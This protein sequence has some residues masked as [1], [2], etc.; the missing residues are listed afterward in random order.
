[1][2][3]GA[4][5]FGGWGLLLPV[6][7]LAVSEAG[8]S[9]AVAAASTAV[10]MASTVIT[11]LFV[12][13]MLMRVGHRAVL[14]A[15]CLLLGLPAL[16]FIVSVEATPALAVSG[17]RGTGFGMLTVAA[18]AIVAELAP[19]PLLGRA[20]GAQG[21]AVALAQMVALPLGLVIFATSPTVVYVAGALVP[22]A[23]L[24][25]VALLPP[26]HPAPQSH[27]SERVRLDARRFL[28]PC[29]V[30]AS[31]SAAYGGVTSLLPIAESDRSAMIGLAL[32]VVSAAMLVGRY[33]A[34]S[35]ADRIGVGRSVAPALAS[36]ATGA[37]LFAVAALGA[38]PAA[39]FFVAAVLFGLGY[40]ACQNDSLVMAFDAAG[41][42]RFSTASAVWNISFDAGTGAGALTL[43]VVATT[44]GYTAGFSVAA[45][46]IAAVA[47]VALVAR[48]LPDRLRR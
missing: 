7:P 35:V 47:A 12:P 5:A 26:T 37:A 19:A 44:I 30:I 11:Q 3:M 32:A 36:A 39:L 34:G 23:G 24:I 9:D 27:I 20:T 48:S 13:R 6:V 18:S 42:A 14:A 17:L 10:F 16:L 25:G 21:I 45:V 38:M 1:M 4:A 41:P 33:T 31:V 22:A 28:L 8:A 15:G 43:G 40:G 29:L 2:G 46:T